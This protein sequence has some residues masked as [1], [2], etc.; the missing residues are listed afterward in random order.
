MCFGI[1]DLFNL[2][3]IPDDVFQLPFIFENEEKIALHHHKN[4]NE[5]RDYFIQMRT[6]NEK[7]IEECYAKLCHDDQICDKN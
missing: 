1:E 4:E 5:L 2:P 7:L 3:V 6:H